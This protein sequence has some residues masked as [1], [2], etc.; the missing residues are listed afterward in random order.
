LLPFLSRFSLSHWFPPMRI[1]P[2]FQDAER[3]TLSVV[4][5]NVFLSETDTP[6]SPLRSP[7]DSNPRHRMVLKSVFCFF[8]QRIWLHGSTFRLPFLSLVEVGFGGVF[9]AP[10]DRI[11]RSF[12]FFRAF[13]TGTVVHIRLSDVS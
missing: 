12:F 13:F 10:L 2:S 9:S 8:L 6:P 1:F 11:I 5:N 7:L 3:P 4:L